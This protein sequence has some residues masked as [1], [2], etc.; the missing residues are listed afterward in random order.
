MTTTPQVLLDWRHAPDRWLHTQRHRRVIASIPALVPGD[1]VL[2]VCHGNVCRSPFA[3]AVLSRSLHGSGILVDSAGFVGPGRPAPL[4]AQV[5]GLELGV[6]LVGHRSQLITETM[7]REAK[8]VIVMD[9]AQRGL[10]R[11]RE[12]TYTPPQL[13]GDLDPLAIEK[14]AIRDPWGQSLP[15][16]VEVFLRI[17]RCAAV[18]ALAIERASGDTSDGS[19]DDA[20]AGRSNGAYTSV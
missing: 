7:L 15:V 4:H 9:V 14:R 3:A 12:L 17:E 16:F 1:R 6:K 19:G 2:V 5:A 18:L 10:L 11:R 20:R 8:L 13:L